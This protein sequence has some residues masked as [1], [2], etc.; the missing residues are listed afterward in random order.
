MEEIG[1]MLLSES[2]CDPIC[3]PIFLGILR[4]G[5]QYRNSTRSS[6]TSRNH[7]H[8]LVLRNTT[9]QGGV[10]GQTTTSAR[11]RVVVSL[12]RTTND[13]ICLHLD[14]W[15]L[16]FMTVF[17]LVYAEHNCLW[18][19]ILAHYLTAARSLA[20]CHEYLIADCSCSHP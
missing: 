17:E 4:G 15:L 20:T 8:G 3:M 9:I 10:G 13:E 2:D 12:I 16:S 6:Q 14:L 5:K 1:N 18:L 19:N 7:G 11:R